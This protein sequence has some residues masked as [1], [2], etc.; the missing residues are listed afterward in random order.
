MTNE[1]GTTVFR[2]LHAIPAL[3]ALPG[4]LVAVKPGHPEPMVLYRGLGEYVGMLAEALEAGLLMAL[5]SHS[6][7][8]PP[9]QRYGS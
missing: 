8:G 6:G 1:S 7:T 5:S 2:V 4:D 3:H 9:S